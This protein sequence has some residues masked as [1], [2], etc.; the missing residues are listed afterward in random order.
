M[1]LFVHN[2]RLRI[3]PSV[4]S[5]FSIDRTFKW[6]NFTLLL[7]N[8]G[9]IDS[10]SNGTR[11]CARSPQTR[12]STTMHLCAACTRRRLYNVAL[13]SALTILPP[14]AT[15]PSRVRVNTRSTQTRLF[16]NAI[17]NVAGLKCIFC[18][19]AGPVRTSCSSQMASCCNTKTFWMKRR[20]T[21]SITFLAKVTYLR[22]LIHRWWSG[23]RRIASRLRWVKRRSKDSRRTKVY[24]QLENMKNG[25][26][27][28]KEYPFCCYVLLRCFLAL[29]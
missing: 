11:R 26:L 13:L 10:S 29:L 25:F 20:S 17:S 14:R 2:R 3:S 7:K 22:D 15:S 9:P 19:V 6:Y 1:V 4:F 18:L 12:A 8:E 28:G 23:S 16:G 5:T 21:F 24:E 27:L